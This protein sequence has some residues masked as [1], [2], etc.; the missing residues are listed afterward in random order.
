M[1]TQKSTI[2][3]NL[4]YLILLV[5][6]LIFLFNRAWQSF[7]ISMAEPV[8]DKGDWYVV[9]SYTGC[10]T[11]EKRLL[12]KT[13]EFDNYPFDYSEKFY[14]DSAEAKRIASSERGLAVFFGI[15]GGIYLW[16]F[17]SIYLNNYI[18]FDGKSI[19]VQTSRFPVSRYYGSYLKNSHLNGTIF[20][21]NITAINIT[22]TTPLIPDRKNLQE[23]NWRDIVKIQSG[24]DSIGIPLFIFPGF[25]KILL[26]I[27][28]KKPG[29]IVEYY[30]NTFTDNIRSQTG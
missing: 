2:R 3:I 22:T 24:S 17:A 10:R 16:L 7:R 4:L 11:Y 9:C 1:P 30:K 20:L 27:H 5:F 6:P 15:L 29:I 8:S 12:Q 18:I 21:E 19:T 23:I 14:N 25:K 13:P 28:R 26:E